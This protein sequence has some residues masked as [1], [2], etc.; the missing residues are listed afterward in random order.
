MKLNNQNNAALI[1]LLH[2]FLIPIGMIAAYLIPSTEEPVGVVGMPLYNLKEKQHS[3][4]ELQSW[5]DFLESPREE[6]LV[7]KDT[8]SETLEKN[9]T[10]GKLDIF[11]SVLASERVDYLADRISASAIEGYLYDWEIKLQDA[12][13]KEANTLFTALYSVIKQKLLDEVAAYDTPIDI[14]PIQTTANPFSPKFST[15]FDKKVPFDR[16]IQLGKACVPAVGAVLAAILVAVA[17]SVLMPG[18]RKL[19]F[20]ISIGL[21]LASTIMLSLVGAGIGYLFALNSGTE[22]ESEMTVQVSH[23]PSSTV[24]NLSSKTQALTEKLNEKLK[25]KK[26]FCHVKSKHF[27]RNFVAEKEMVNWSSFQP[28]AEA[29]GFEAEEG[30]VEKLSDYIMD[31][32]EIEQDP[33]ASNIYTFRF[34]CK[35]TA[36]ARGLLTCIVDD[37]DAKLEEVNKSVMG[38]PLACSYEINRSSADIKK[39]RW[40]GI[41]SGHIF[42]GALIGAVFSLV[43]VSSTRVFAGAPM[44]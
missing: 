31:R 30:A 6:T 8:L 20:T 12:S 24:G 11:S 38:G 16:S 35:D 29:R 2:S 33:I 5:L 7:G 39:V 10:Q 26:H 41:A 3:N 44:I 25:I 14:L 23:V 19:P 27:I 13:R 40:P 36:D 42:Q 32:L 21:L 34:R 22:W 15:G 1:L 43:I 18:Q 28:I 9:E 4:A 37:Y 17:W